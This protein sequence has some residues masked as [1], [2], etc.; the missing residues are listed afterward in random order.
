MQP[1][2][3][4]LRRATKSAPQTRLRGFTNM[5]QYD[6]NYFRM[7]SIYSYSSRNPPSD[8]PLPEFLGSCWL[9]LKEK[10]NLEIIN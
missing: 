5:E 9:N 6:K 7:D 1:C 10:R 4:T 2:I 8:Q 3:K